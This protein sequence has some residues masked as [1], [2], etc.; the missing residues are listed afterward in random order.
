MGLLNVAGYFDPLL[1]LLDHAMTR[2]FVRRE[3][4]DLLVVSTD[5]QAIIEDLAGRSAIHRP[6]QMVDFE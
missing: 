4:L 6:R 1:A 2:G 5:P 3:F